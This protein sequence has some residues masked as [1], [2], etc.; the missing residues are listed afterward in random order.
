MI[1]LDWAIRA[2]SLFN[3]IALLW[4]GLTVLLNT[5][6]HT[7]GS[8]LASGGLLMGGLFFVA[9]TLIA[10]GQWERF[11]TELALWSRLVWLPCIVLPYLWYLVMLWWTGV[12]QD[13]RQRL[14]LAGM[15]ALGLLG[16]AVLALYPLQLV[17][18]VPRDASPLLVPDDNFPAVFLV[19]PAYSL[20]SITLALWALRHMAASDRFMGDLA[21]LRA[22]PWLIAA[23]LSL[24][25]VSL[26]VGAIALWF[27]SGLQSGAL[28]SISEDM[29]ARL[30]PFDALIA[31]LI[32]AAVI[33][34]GRAVV[35]YEIFTGK[36]LP[37]GALLLQWR[38]SLLL[39]LGYSIVIAA[40]LALPLD[41]IYSLLLATLIMVAYVALLGWR[42]DVDHTRRMERLRPVV[43]SQR[44]YEHLL[45]PADGEG[46][47]AGFQLAGGEASV[48]PA[49]PPVRDGDVSAPF[50]AVCHDL[51]GAEV[52]YL[53]AL[54]P[55][56][57]LVGPPLAIP[58]DAAPPISALTGLL[59]ELRAPE[60]LCLPI[61]PAQ[62][63]GAH[64]AIPLWSERGLIG[65]LLLGNKHNSGLYT[66]EEI[67]MARATGERLI[68]TQASAEMA[69]RLMALQRQ[70]LAES[71]L[72]DNRTRRV[73]HD[74]V[75]PRLHT[76]MLSLSAGTA[77]NGASDTASSATAEAITLLADT[78]RQIANL[79]RVLPAPTAPEIARLG[80]IGALRH[81][82]ER[83]LRD[84]FE[85]VTW[86][87]EPTAEEAAS[88]LPP[89][90]AEVLFGAAREAMR[91]SARY[92]Q[93]N[94]PR[95]P[96]HLTIALAW[97]GE[98][99]LTIE[100]D[101]VGFGAT[102]SASKGS[103]QGLALHST[104]LAVLGG[105]LTA[106]RLPA[107]GSVVV[108]ALPENGLLTLRL[109]PPHPPQT[110][111]PPP[112]TP[113]HSPPA[114]NSP[115]LAHALRPDQPAPDISS[116]PPGTSPAPA[117]GGSE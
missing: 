19:Y 112:Q 94:D 88:H 16:L 101:G 58:D 53:L 96:L 43:A 84:A 95:R 24:L 15:T 4:L 11:N 35:S 13:Y 64:W 2:V 17:G 42:L 57:P 108:L 69:R 23:S 91:N 34:I 32:A 7:W 36:R 25:A 28:L 66:Q 72:L 76:T 3:T 37:S 47:T 8:L 81:V 67:E 83:E 41:P 10:A 93:G 49:S 59:A 26:G 103:G 111:L 55:L 9:H 114:E 21:R 68:D 22:R 97:R 80:L 71:Q 102:D 79:L 70:R 62:Y 54:G 27:L 115:L 109:H 104:M 51:L 75:L 18:A 92:G 100:D 33:F 31:S 46:R 117:S 12:L 6:R 106:E 110:P 30:K 107:G 39:A 82:V 50:R 87:L 48:P 105:T 78:H 90:A 45:S 5:E 60:K 1:L 99:R 74:D 40:S 113:V 63:H 29:L 44:L 98:L 65:V 89:L 61:E 14:I 38:R 56:A 73:L 116:P 77:A 20:L 85:R 52:A 86:Q